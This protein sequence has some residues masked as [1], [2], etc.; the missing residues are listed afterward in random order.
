MRSI[1]KISFTTIILACAVLPS[2]SVLAQNKSNY[3]IEYR[4]SAS[5]DLA[6]R[7]IIARLN[8]SLDAAD[9]KAYSNHFASDAVFATTFGN[10]IGPEKIV[11][12]LEQSRPFI[13]G[14]RHI[15]TNLVISS[16]G[17]RAIVTSYLTVFERETSLA[18]LGSAINIDT[19]EKRGGKWLVVKHETEMDPATLAAIKAV[20]GTDKK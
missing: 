20:M 8:H 14:K 2:V 6:I 17:N 4:I 7:Q 13:T 18:Y 3:L 11:A 10:A 19:L 9:Y 12:A 1:S 15:A 16:S 5:D